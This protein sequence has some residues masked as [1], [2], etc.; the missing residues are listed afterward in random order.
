MSMKKKSLRDTDDVDYPVKDC[1]LTETR[2][3][4]TQLFS[5]L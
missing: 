1:L 3:L 4:T 2:V 5:H